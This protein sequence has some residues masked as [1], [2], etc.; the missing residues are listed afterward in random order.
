M[1]DTTTKTT[2]LI[3]FLDTIGRTILGEVT[4]SND[5]TELGVK[6]PV[7]LQVIQTDQSGRMSVQLLPIFFREFLSDKTGDY[8]FHFKKNNITTSDIDALDFR[9]QAQYEQMF[10]KNNAFVAPQPQQP[11]NSQSV[12][13]L[14]DE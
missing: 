1:S 6:N 4:T 14:F 3:T 7:I 8:V 5:E 13:N 9:L 11:D 2:K 10:N 12:I